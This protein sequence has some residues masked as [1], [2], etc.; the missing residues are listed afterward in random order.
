MDKK[1]IEIII[2][3]WV[4]SKH[5]FNKTVIFSIENKIC[6]TKKSYAT[7]NIYKF[8]P[9]LIISKINFL[10]EKNELKGKFVTINRKQ[11]LLIHRNN[12]SQ[13]IPTKI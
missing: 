13:L 3:Y 8:R 11:Q 6:S 10:I 9:S 7:K 1:Y 12:S 2:M 4:G 5:Y